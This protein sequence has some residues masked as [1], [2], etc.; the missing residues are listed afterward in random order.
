MI[1]WLIGFVVGVGVGFCIALWVVRLDI[2]AKEK[3]GRK[4][5][6]LEAS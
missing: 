3:A 2:Q 5:T 6:D 4:M 1:G